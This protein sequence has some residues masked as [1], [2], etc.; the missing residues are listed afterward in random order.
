[1]A[2]VLLKIYIYINPKVND[3]ILKAVIILLRDMVT[4]SMHSNF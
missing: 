1:M 2:S 4:K 3:F